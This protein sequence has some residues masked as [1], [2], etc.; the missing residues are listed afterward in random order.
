MSS[1]LEGDFFTTEPP[2]KPPPQPDMGFLLLKSV[3]AQSN[4]ED[5]VTPVAVNPQNDSEQNCVCVCV[6]A[7]LCICVCVY[8]QLLVTSY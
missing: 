8:V 6:W 4:G 7:C 5:L 2:E 3:K 1:A